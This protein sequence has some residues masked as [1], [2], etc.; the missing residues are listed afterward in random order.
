MMSMSLK[1]GRWIASM[2]ALV[3]LSSFFVSAFGASPAM[4]VAHASLSLS[5]QTVPSSIGPGDNGN[6]VLTVANTGTEYARAVSL[7]VKPNAQMTLGQQQYNLQIIAPSTSVQ[8]S[9]PI[10]ISTSASEGA[11]SVF[12]SLTYND[13]ESVG[14]VVT[15]TSVSVTIS[16]RSLVQVEGVSWGEGMIEPGDTLDVGVQ[17]RNAGAGD[18]S[19]MTVTL[20][21]SAQPFV[22]AAKDT[23]AYV[24]SLRQGATATAQ[25]S[26]IVNRDARTIAYSVPVTI[27]YYDDAGAAHSDVKYVGLKVSGTPEFVVALEDDA[28]ALAGAGGDVTISIANRG[29]ATA[30]LLTIKFGAGIPVTPAEY[31]VGNLDPDSFQTVKVNV[32]LAGVGPGAHDLAMTLE[33]KDPYNQDMSSQASVQFAARHAPA[34]AVSPTTVITILAIVAGLLYWKRARIAGFLQKFRRAKS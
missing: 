21:D 4:A 31:Y 23:E 30:N 12:V 16:K 2:M 9:V 13:G 3:I 28:S 25:F 27:A 34:F 6:L 17:L 24:G 32:D 7:F 26:I 10:T 8:V 20:G 22:A 15:E 33:Y 29:T 1:N 18:L 14:A 19:Y 11:T 5:G